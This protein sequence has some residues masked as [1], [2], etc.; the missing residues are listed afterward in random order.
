MRCLNQAGMQARIVPAKRAIDIGRDILSLKD[1]GQLDQELYDIYLSKYNYG[2][3]D[4]LPTAKSLLVVAV[5]TSGLTITFNHHGKEHRCRVPPTYANAKEIDRKVKS[6]LEAALPEC[7][8][9]KAILPFKTLATRTG[10][11]RYGKNN[12]TYAEDLGSFYRLT[13]FFSDGDMETDDWQPRE[14]MAQCADCDLCLK[15]C[16]TGAIGKDRFLIRADRCLTFLNELPSERAFPSRIKASVH[17][18]I[19]GCMKCQDVCPM[20]RELLGSYVDG[21]VYSEEE[22]DYLLKGDYQNDDAEEIMEKLDCSGLDLEIFPRNLAV[23]LK[24]KADRS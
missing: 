12:I 1:E 5:P 22:T 20:N 9:V 6:I 13:G 16:P 10:L 19:V 8:F 23:L 7:R 2:L 3:P 21:D 11:A 17:N 18:A 15:A 14:V 24:G 4:S